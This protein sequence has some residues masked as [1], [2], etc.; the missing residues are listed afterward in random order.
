MR[1]GGGGGQGVLCPPPPKKNMPKNMPKYG[2]N[3]GK[4]C[5][6]QMSTSYTPIRLC[7]MV[8]QTRR[9]SI[10]VSFVFFSFFL[11][12]SFFLAMFRFHLSWL[13]SFI[14]F[15]KIMIYNTI[16]NFQSKMR[17]SQAQMKQVYGK[18]RWMIW[19]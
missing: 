6:P 10:A 8:F 9:L 4:M 11:F 14:V 19:H 13:N 3:S 16:F 17:E 12:S 1:R 2:Q 15:K 18:K 7:P 5:V